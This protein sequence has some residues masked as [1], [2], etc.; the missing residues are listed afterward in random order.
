[1]MNRR[2][3]AWVGW[4]AVILL[5]CAHQAVVQPLGPPP[6]L[7]VVGELVGPAGRLPGMA[8]AISGDRISQVAPA[9]ELT[10]RWPSVQRVNAPYMTAGFVD[11]HAHPGWV[12][13]VSEQVDLTGVTSY[14]AALSLLQR[15]APAA[16]WVQG[17]G[18]DQTRWKDMPEGGWPL[19]SDLDR[20]LPGRDV[21]LSRIDGHAVWVSSSVLGRI[22]DWG[23]AASGHVTRDSKGKPSGVL[24]DDAM[25]AV[26]EV[27]TEEA[28]VRRQLLAAL[29]QMADAGLTG[30]HAMSVSDNELLALTSLAEAQ[31]LPIRVWAFLQPDGEGAARLLAEGPR[32]VGRLTVGGIKTF[33]DGALGS[34]GA[35]LHAPYADQPG[36][37][38]LPQTTLEDLTTLI[39]HAA[40]SGVQVATHAIGDAG[41][42]MVLDAVAAARST[43][44][45]DGLRMR[46][47]HAQV[48][49]EGAAQR[50][51]PLNIVASIQPRHVT[52]DMDWAEARVGPERMARAYAWRDLLNAGAMVAAGSDA[53]VEPFDPALGMWAAVT[54]TD[55]AGQPSGGFRPEQ[56]LTAGEAL[57][58]FTWGAARAVHAEHDLGR[59][60]P[61]YKAD[62]TLWTTTRDQ[63]KVMGI[64]VDGAF[65]LN[66]E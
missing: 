52:S 50:F 15:E 41:C 28:D 31:S 35:H 2:T 16:G 58:A 60:A 46:M 54:R 48:L 4:T 53:P 5:G 27:P 47:E 39:H 14:E 34:R 1:M 63:W 13:Q 66:E 9:N 18:W 44:G 20:V 42:D 25:A 36:H 6:D 64:I 51:A 11:A 17:H 19:A 43:S 33:A 23:D 38:G 22:S 57:E 37:R 61:G 21:V 32:T 45:V 3:V 12:G 7:V 29:G 8:V 30:V 55:D 56:G 26:P 62:L 49:S 10:A 65:A 24:V 59:I 40:S